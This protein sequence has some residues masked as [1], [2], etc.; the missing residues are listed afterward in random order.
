MVALEEYFKIYISRFPL[1]K[2]Y[3]EFIDSANLALISQCKGVLHIGAHLG[4]E[5][6]A[7]SALGKPAI[8]IEADPVTFL[9][10]EKNIISRKDQKAFNLLLGD[11]EGLVQFFRASNGSESSSVY[12]FS[13]QNRFKN[14]STVDQLELKM[15]R[16]DSSFTLKQLQEYDHWV[17]D[18]QGAELLVLRGAGDLLDACRT[19]LVECSRTEFYKGGARWSEIETF[20]AENGFRYFLSPGNLNHLNVLFFKPNPNS[21]N[22]L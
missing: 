19:L 21:I 11:K 9:Q 12:S 16:L 3:G 18:V 10:L 5:S 13:S 1:E 8:F 15:T 6:E 2:Y 4:L 14:V 7:Y 22:E 20:L 17:I